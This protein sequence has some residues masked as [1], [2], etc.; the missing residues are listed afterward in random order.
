[1]VKFILF[2]FL[3]SF[4]LVAQDFSALDNINISKPEIRQSLL[5]LHK[6][7]KIS[8]ADLKKALAELDGLSKKEVD[9]LIKK[10]SGILKGQL[11]SKKRK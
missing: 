2:L 11:Q 5:Q 9:V 8:N 10:G 4:S 1:M 7:G 6:M 3:F